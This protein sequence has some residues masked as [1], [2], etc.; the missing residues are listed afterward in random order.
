M[1]RS[2]MPSQTQSSQS[3]LFRAAL[4]RQHHHMALLPNERTV[5]HLLHDQAWKLIL[6]AWLGHNNASGF[7]EEIVLEGQKHD[8]RPS[9][10]VEARDACEY[11]DQLHI[12]HV[13]G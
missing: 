3:D 1:L 7:G 6:G 4:R 9:P 11:F 12:G 5:G 2:R 10:P 13:G 8:Q